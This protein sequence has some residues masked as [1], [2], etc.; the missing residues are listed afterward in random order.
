MSYQ[1]VERGCR[2]S[3]LLQFLF[4]HMGEM[5]RV[6]I[7][8]VVQNLCSVVRV[9]GGKGKIEITQSNKHLNEAFIYKSLEI[10]DPRFLHMYGHRV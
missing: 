6:F 10:S 3:L 7:V 5:V 8:R 1:I 4:P 9:R 2:L